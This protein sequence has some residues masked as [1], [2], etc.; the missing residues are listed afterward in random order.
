MKKII[1]AILFALSLS[2]HGMTVEPIKNLNPK[3]TSISRTE[4]LWIY[5][6]RTR[7]WDDGRKITVFYLDN[8]SVTHKIFVTEVLKTTPIQFQ[9]A[10][11]AYVNVGNSAYF[12]QVSSEFEMLK[13]L[14]LTPGSV[15]YISKDILLINGGSDV[16]KIQIT[17]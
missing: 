8:T 16:K 5:T 3:I 17:D 7:F 15:G 2:C 9:T 12:R 6:M 10:I 1:T 13:Q 14:E 11:N 4:V